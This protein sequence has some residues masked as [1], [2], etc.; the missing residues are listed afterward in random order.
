[1]KFL[2]NFLRRSKMAERNSW[3]IPEGINLDELACS[4][5][6][7]DLVSSERARGLTRSVNGGISWQI[8]GGN[9]EQNMARIIANVQLMFARKFP[10]FVANFVNEDD[11]MIDAATPEGAST[12]IVENIGTPKGFHDLVGDS[13]SRVI[14]AARIFG[15][16]H[17]MALRRTFSAWGL[18]LNLPHLEAK[19]NSKE[20]LLKL[21]DFLYG[22]ADF[23]ALQAVVLP[24][25]DVSTE[26]GDDIVTHFYYLK[27]GAYLNVPVPA[28]LLLGKRIRVVPNQYAAGLEPYHWL[29]IYGDADSESE[30]FSSCGLYPNSDRNKIDHIRWHGVGEEVLTDFIDGRNGIKVD[31]V[32]P[33]DFNVG[34]RS[35]LSSYSI[36]GRAHISLA[37]NE[38]NKIANNDVLRFVTRQDETG[39]YTWLDI[40]KKLDGISSDQ[41]PIVS[42]HRILLE[43]H[44]LENIW[45]GVE[46]QIFLDYLAGDKGI[47]FE[48]LKS[49]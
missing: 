11:D 25:K 40:Y 48:S 8:P 33:F 28:R 42:S 4:S 13:G 16:T 34:Q 31:D 36:A 47:N 10:Q 9:Y 18:D 35:R 22:G 49:I 24:L 45:P 3:P 43:E 41:W 46:R 26:S 5:T 21:R 27:T 1:M 37:L 23:S 29:D 19:Q 44:K 32:T 39:K 6:F 12:F 17:T 20:G 7:Q 38:N 30:P 14:R 2:E 15:D